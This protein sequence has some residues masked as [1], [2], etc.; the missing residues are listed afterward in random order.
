MIYRITSGD[1]FLNFLKGMEIFIPKRIVPDYN[2]TTHG[3]FKSRV[4]TE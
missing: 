3:K 4:D 2:K 1:Y